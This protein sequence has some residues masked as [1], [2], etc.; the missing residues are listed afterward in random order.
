MT[1]VRAAAVGTASTME[2]ATTVELIPA[3]EGAAIAPE[4]VTAAEI[5]ARGSTIALKF[6]AA[7]EVAPAPEI[8]EAITTESA[9]VIKI[10]AEITI[11]GPEAAVETVEPG[12]SA[13]KNAAVEVFRAVISV[14]RASVRVISVVA[15]RAVGRWADVY[16]RRD[17]GR[18][19]SN[20]DPKSNL[21]MR[22]RA[23]E[24]YQKP[25]QTK[26]S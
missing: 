1:A 3:A 25:E 8:A 12:A 4:S 21:G 16:R 7:M 9:V 2:S 20:A 14:R 23:R 6:T 19:N 15:V 13:E 26:I 17:I 24:N 11:A 18:T 10:P 22:D 5:S